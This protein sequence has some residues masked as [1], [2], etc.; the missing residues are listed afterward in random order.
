[1]GKGDT[2]KEDGPG[3]GHHDYRVKKT[4]DFSCRRKD[5]MSFALWSVSTSLFERVGYLYAYNHRRFITT[6]VGN[7]QTTFMPT[8]TVG[9]LQRTTAMSTLPD[10]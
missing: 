9:L 3:G 1:M 7:E 2:E 8:T 6:D 10:P 4:C 5:T